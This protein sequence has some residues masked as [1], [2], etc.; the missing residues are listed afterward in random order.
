VQSSPSRSLRQAVGPSSPFRPIYSSSHPALPRALTGSFFP[1]FPYN[2]AVVRRS[3]WLSRLA[4]TTISLDGQHSNENLEPVFGDNL[5]YSEALQVDWPVGAKAGALLLSAAMFVLGGLFMGSSLVRA[6]AP[7]VAVTN[8]VIVQEGS[9]LYPAKGWRWSCS[10][11]SAL[12]TE[13][14]RLADTRSTG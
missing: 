1:G 10:R 7:L 8:I 14:R 5:E 12:P 9:C 2:R 13:K 3:W 6:Y 11:V 4:S